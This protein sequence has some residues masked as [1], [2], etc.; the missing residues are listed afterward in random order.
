MFL[1]V[2]ANDMPETSMPTKMGVY[3]YMEI[4]VR[5]ISGM[6]IDIC[7]TYKLSSIN[8]KQEHYTQTMLTPTS[9]TAMMT[10][11]T[12]PSKCI[13]WVGTFTKFTK[14]EGEIP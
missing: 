3:V 4:F 8:M 12:P 1:H 11:M 9:N 14:N 10:S 6:L 7:A 13:G 2:I 5:H